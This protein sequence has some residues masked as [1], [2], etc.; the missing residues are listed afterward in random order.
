MGAPPPF[1]KWDLLDVLKTTYDENGMYKLD[2]ELY[3][4][5]QQ[6]G[7]RGINADPDFMSRLLEL[8]DIFSI[9]WS[10][11]AFYEGNHQHKV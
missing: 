9:R 4:K 1:F 10:L 5:T 2:L 6:T 11:A 8:G 3:K 7:G